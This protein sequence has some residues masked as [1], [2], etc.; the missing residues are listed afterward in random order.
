M[1]TTA[2][3][4][5]TVNAVNDVPT[6][7]TINAQETSEETDITVDLSGSDVDIVCSRRPVAIHP[8][9]SLT[10]STGSSTATL[11]LCPG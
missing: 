9:S 6:L 2:T 8:L 7:T 3:V 11:S 10:T 5:I 1:S 4:D